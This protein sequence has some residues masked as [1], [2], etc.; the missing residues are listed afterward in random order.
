MLP[1]NHRFLDHEIRLEIH[2]RLNPKRRKV[3][4]SVSSKQADLVG[5]ITANLATIIPLLER[6]FMTFHE[7]FD[8]DF[9][10][11]ITHPHVWLAANPKEEGAWTFVVERADNPD[12]G[13]HAEF[14][15]AD[16]VELW[17]GD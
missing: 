8:P 11:F 2:T 9:R 4:P 3:L 1:D 5:K 13:Y 10:R 7:K 14:K 17:A 6:E 12:F 15:D 16:F